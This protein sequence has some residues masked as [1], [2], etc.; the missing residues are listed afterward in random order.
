MPKNSPPLPLLLCPDPFSPDPI[1]ET[2]ICSVNASD[3]KM[4]PNSSV[5][6]TGAA[7]AAAAAGATATDITGE[8][9]VL[10]GKDTGFA[11]L[12]PS[13]GLGSVWSAGGWS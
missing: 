13:W 6:E 4:S 11:W 7:I 9:R 10:T 2:T 8:F 12:A 3:G 5:V 1:A